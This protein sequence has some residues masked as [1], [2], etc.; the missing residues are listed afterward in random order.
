MLGG[1][2]RQALPGPR[3]NKD[4]RTGDPQPMVWAG[5]KKEENRCPSDLS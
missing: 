5:K 3:L 2:G 4:Y 1:Y